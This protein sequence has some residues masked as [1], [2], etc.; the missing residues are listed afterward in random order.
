MPILIRCIKR[1]S[2]LDKPEEVEQFVEVEFQ[3]STGGDIDLSPSFYE[4]QDTPQE[5]IQVYT[6]HAASFLDVPRGGVLVDGSGLETDPPRTTP[7]TTLFEFANCHH[8][9]IHFSDESALR[10]FAQALLRGIADRR[11]DVSQRE[12]KTYVA[13]KLGEKDPE[14]M[15]CFAHAP[16]G[17]KWRSWAEKAADLSEGV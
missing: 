1:R 11:R 14:W 6:E 12:I 16:R 2:S 9:E 5:L 10:A 7:G 17:A 13:A 4:I 8:R 15:G 3:R